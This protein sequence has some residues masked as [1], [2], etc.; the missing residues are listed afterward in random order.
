MLTSKE[1]SNIIGGELK[2]N[3][4]IEL[5]TIHKIENAKK[6]AVSFVAREP[7]LKFLQSTNASAII[8]DKN[9][10]FEY[11]ERKDRAYLIVDN[12]YY[13]LSKL[14]K[15]VEEE[16]IERNG[17]S[18]LSFVS[19]NAKLAEDISIGA[20]SY[21][22]D[23]VKM[24][25]G[26]AISTHVFIGKDVVI[27]DNVSIYPGVKIYNGCK[28]GNNCTIHSNTVIGS[29]GFGFKPN[30]AGEYK[31]TPQVGIVV[32]EDNVEVGANVVIDRA[33]FDETVIHKGVKLDN[34]IQVAHNVEVGENT[35]IAAQ[36]GIAGSTTIGK[37][38]II[39]GQAGFSGHIKIADGSQFQ[40]QSGVMQSIIKENGK[41]QGSPAISFMNHLKSFLVFK[42]L[43]ELQHKI[44]TLEK[45]IEN[46][47]K[48][49][50]NE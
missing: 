44:T 22:S 18:D 48:L 13:A 6:G 47:K 39:G 29:D 23:N 36:T 21:V 35:V 25:S 31:K 10:K 4:D 7:Y 30:E 16:K 8:I 11:E 50:N 43:P 28:I 14:L 1:I 9:F 49:L 26:C 32:L 17:I 46:L 38:V 34:L 2:G 42:K 15:Y 12:V 45:E 20:F 40:A 5:T 19:K 27:G 3:P 24:G 41:Y 33:T 37:N